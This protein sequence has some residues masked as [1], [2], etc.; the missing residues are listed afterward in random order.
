MRLSRELHSNAPMQL[1]LS[2]QKLENK[3][4]IGMVFRRGALADQI[5]DRLGGLSGLFD[6]VGSTSMRLMFALPMIR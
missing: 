4:H 2:F 6:Q 5:A 1:Q 3:N